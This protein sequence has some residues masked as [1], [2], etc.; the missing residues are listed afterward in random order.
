MSRKQIATLIDTAFS[1]LSRLCDSSDNAHGHQVNLQ[2]LFADLCAECDRG[3]K[4]H[5]AFGR[6]L[7]GYKPPRKATHATRVRYFVVKA[8]T[9]QDTRVTCA[10][11]A[12][13]T[14]RDRLIGAAIR[15][16]LGQDL[17]SE[18][19][20]DLWVDLEALDYARDLA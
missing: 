16:V 5:I 12:V 20:A 7:L 1:R 11:D 17:V 8:I 13:S 3:E 2:R 19:L 9:S 4:E 6:R 10:L 18:T 14:R 15:Q